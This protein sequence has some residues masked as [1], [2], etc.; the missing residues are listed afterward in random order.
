MCWDFLALVATVGVLLCWD[1]FLIRLLICSETH[2]DLIWSLSTSLHRSFSP[3]PRMLGVGL[4]RHDPFKAASL[5][6][7]A[8]GRLWKSLD[9]LLGGILTSAKAGGVGALLLSL[10]HLVLW[11]SLEARGCPQLVLWVCSQPRKAPNYRGS[12]SD[13]HDTSQQGMWVG[14]NAKKKTGRQENRDR[15]TEIVRARARYQR[16]GKGS[17][18]EP[19]ISLENVYPGQSP[20]PTTTLLE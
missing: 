11:N 5:G 7:Q 17:P 13:R 14:W 18:E 4:V 20:L 10:C 8:A 9:A 1:C 16:W 3:C 12:S 15:V 6:T 2:I 19:W